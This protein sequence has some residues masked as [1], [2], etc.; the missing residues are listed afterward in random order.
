[1][2]FIFN[3]T[4][5]TEI[6]TYLH[7]LSLHDALPSWQDVPRVHRLGAVREP[8]EAT[9]QQ[10]LA[11]AEDRQQRRPRI[12]RARDAFDLRPRDPCGNRRVRR[13]VATAGAERQL[14][15]EDR[16]SVV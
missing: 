11:P 12:G 4:A 14:D 5:S 15:R 9:I 10:N 8:A 13:Q 1:M 16:T 2:C 3:A 6:Y 7:A